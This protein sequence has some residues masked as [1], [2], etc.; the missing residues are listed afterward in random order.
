[1]SAHYALLL[2]IKAPWRVQS[3]RLDLLASKVEI[4]VEW[5]ETAQVCCPECALE[6]PRHDRARRSGRGGTDVMQFQ[7]IIRARVPRSR[8]AEHGVLTVR[9]PWA[10]PALALHLAL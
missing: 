7:T 9:A 2:G 1:M 10:E 5:D 4:A 6:C 3:A 8:C